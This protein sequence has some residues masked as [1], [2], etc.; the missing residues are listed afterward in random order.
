VSR[1]TTAVFLDLAG[2]LF[3][4]RDLRDAHLVQ[5]R[6]V[7][8]Q[9]GADRTDSQLRTAYRQG[10]GTAYPAVA[11]GP[12][13]SHRELFGG[14]F[15]AM[16]RELG[17]ALTTEQVRAAVDR[18]YAATVDSVRLRPDCLAT[19]TALR[20]RGLH[21]QVV[22]NIDD[23][24]LQP[25]VRH[26]GLDQVLDTWTSSEEAGSC[27]PD[28]VIFRYALAK[29]GAEADEALFVGD[30]VRH[31]IDGAAAVG[32]RTALLIADHPAPDPPPPHCYLITSLSG[33]TAL[34]D[35]GDPA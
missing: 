30:T 24:Q 15:A 20:D 6:W 18:Q 19:L 17:G 14:A 1:P 4:D 33:I 29:A 10:M 12:S 28:A 25:L 7:A 31:D 11:S 35:T 16:A 3:S 9:V 5:L 8:E 22:S 34:I 26:T 23:E 27:K 21:L 32:M 2:T 13:Y